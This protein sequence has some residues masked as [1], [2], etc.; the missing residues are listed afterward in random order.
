MSVGT[1]LVRIAP[2]C[3]LVGLV[4]GLAM[5]I[6]KDRALTSVHSHVLL[7]GWATMAISGIVYIVEPRCAKRKLA[8]LHFWGHNAGLPVMMVSLGFVQYG[9]S[10]AEPVIGV[11]SIIVLGSLVVF[12]LNDFSVR[13]VPPAN[14]ASP[15]SSTS[16]LPGA[17]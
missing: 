9:Y 11:G 2:I 8:A 6:S 5:A 14:Q 16:A 13:G 4:M 7:L 15:E 17:L 1:K 3:M 12:T 10:A